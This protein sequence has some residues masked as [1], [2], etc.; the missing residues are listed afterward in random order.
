MA[1]GEDAFNLN[2]DDFYDDSDIELNFETKSLTIPLGEP[3]I[4]SEPVE[5]GNYSKFEYYMNRNGKY[6]FR[7]EDI[8]FQI[9]A[10]E[11][12]EFM[13]NYKYGDMLEVKLGMNN[14]YDKR[15]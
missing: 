13:K 6:Y 7:N 15:K 2:V 10:D 12:N 4:Y 9:V 8:K 3:F 14:T 11:M 1:V 5:N